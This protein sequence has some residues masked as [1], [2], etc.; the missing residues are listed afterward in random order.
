MQVRHAAGAALLLCATMISG[1]T[2]AWEKPFSLGAGF[3]GTSFTAEG[4]ESY[5]FSGIAIT[6]SAAFSN[7][8]AARVTYFLLEDETPLPVTESE[9][10]DVQLLLGTGLLY[11][12][13]KAYGSVGVFR[14]NWSM[15]T[16]SESFTGGQL[17]FGLGYNW[18]ALTLDFAVNLRQARDYKQKAYFPVADLSVGSSMLSLALRF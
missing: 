6:G 1:A 9:G 7:N 8:L 16:L 18:P 3:Y 5:D 11:E 2:L 12:G 17:G 14:D 4:Y 10:A 13:F 15:G